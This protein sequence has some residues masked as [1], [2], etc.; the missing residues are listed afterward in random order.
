MADYQ[1]R[2]GGSPNEASDY[3]S[4]DQVTVFGSGTA[5]DPLRTGDVFT[6]AGAFLHSTP[7][8]A[9]TGAIVAGEAILP[10]APVRVHLATLLNAGLA[11]GETDSAVVGLEIL[12]AV[13]AGDPVRWIAAGALELTA[14]QWD[15]VVQGGSGGL[16]P[17]TAYFVND[18]GSQKALRAT[19][20]TAGGHFVVQVG[21]A[22][23]STVMLVQ[24]GPSQLIAGG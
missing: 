15:A 20:P 14:A 24:S 1:S 5:S 3:T 2:A 9:T 16:V 19:R 21:I 17:G 4:A 7:F 23:T 11:T 6:T 12:E 18:N 13:E 22:L 8:D 10:G